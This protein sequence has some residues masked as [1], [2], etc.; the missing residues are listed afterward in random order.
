MNGIKEPVNTLIRYN[1]LVILIFFISG[2][3]GLIYETLWIKML[4]LILGNSIYAI[5]LVVATY[6]AGLGIGGLLAGRYIEKRRDQLR[7]YAILEFAIGIYAMASPFIIEFLKIAYSLA[8]EQLASSILL[9]NGYRLLLAFLVLL[10]P[11][12]IMGATLPV[13]SKYLVRR[14]S[15]LGA[16]IGRLY[17]FNTLGAMLGTV[18]AGFFLVQ[19]FGVLL[20]IYLTAALNIAVG[21]AA[22]LLQKTS[23]IAQ[24]N[25]I[26]EDYNSKAK[27]P[28]RK[29]PKSILQLI[30]FTF[31]ITGFT[32]I[33]YEVIWTRALAFFVGHTTYAFTT[34]LATFLMGLGLGSV[35]ISRFS[36]R[37]K[38]PI[39]VLG[40]IEIAIGLSGI[41]GLPLIDKA[42]YLLENMTG[43]R[44]WGTP[45]WIK[46]INTSAVMLLPA[47]LMGIAFPLASRIFINIKSVGRELGKVYFIN[48]TGGI[49][50][51]FAAVFILIPYMG[52]QISTISIAVINILLGILLLFNSPEKFKFGKR[53]MAIAALGLFI[54]MSFVFYSS[55]V[56]S[57]T[58]RVDWGK[59]IYYR[60]GLN[61][62]I[63]I[64]ERSDG[65]RDLF[66][67]GE[68]N[69]STSPSGKLV[70]MLLAQLPILLH[71]NPD[72]ILVVGLGSGM[73]SG[74]ALRFDGCRVTCAEIS[75]DIIDAARRFSEWNKPL[76]ESKN[77][78]FIVDDGRITLLT[79]PRKYDIII[80]GIIHPKYNPGN[81]SL[82]SSDYY[83]LCKSRLDD[84]G[85]MCQWLPLNAL[86]E[87][88][89][90][91]II[92][93][94]MS[95][96]RHTSLWFEELYGGPGNYNAILIGTNSV[97]QYNYGEIKKAAFGSIP[98]FLS[99]EDYDIPDTE[100][101]L[102]RFIAVDEDLSKYAGSQPLI[103]DNNPR[104]EFGTVEVKDF[105]K[106]LGDLGHVKKNI[107]P[108]LADLPD[109]NFEREQIQLRLEKLN[110][111][112]KACIIGDAYRRDGKF[113]EFIRQYRIATL[114]APQNRTLRDKLGK[115]FAGGFPDSPV[116]EILE[117]QALL[118]QKKGQIDASIELAT[119]A[120]ALSPEKKA[121]KLELGQMFQ[122]AKR[123]DEAI[124]F[125]NE[126]LEHEPDFLEI[127]N[128]LGI[129]YMQKN[130]FADAEREFEIITRQNA[131]FLPMLVNKALLY[132]KTDR[133]EMAIT[134]LKRAEQLAPGDQKIKAL[135]TDLQ[136]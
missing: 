2:A 42:F 119:I 85:I 46:F 121:I 15:E 92:G 123:F 120:M 106:I 30:L 135:V 103:T 107:W 94:F 41:L 56:F 19:F 67:D 20:S 55:G 36:D 52:I 83:K 43:R 117:A 45:I 38:S 54:I 133:R 65:S 113:L 71:K 129:V 29:Y 11:T 77:V 99:Y 31:A 14:N 86:R 24:S 126:I 97:Q 8:G 89:F 66:I 69:A 79:D 37:I 50:G 73:T 64:L 1:P 44:V 22:L 10:P 90:K 111:L 104:L 25:H 18:A 16:G 35:I 118:L 72:D 51:S 75:S 109:S 105:S 130:L 127:R 5:S 116:D 40:L 4:S 62:T 33:A 26:Q 125:Y 53:L 122:S 17:G 49:M 112:S 23:S 47:V 101:L 57:A 91:M 131:E 21:I 98:S 3:C 88:E 100:H 48:T 27:E 70:H 84:N 28:P 39:A 96:F 68:L 34:I 134:I 95:V 115:L 102:D 74:A 9:L 108:Y 61:N 7:I 82:Y 136:K 59:S 6:M 81:A 12:I 63:E 128:N 13:L 58:K 124:E 114:I 80:T 87:S 93:T 60:E 78:N 132:A 110:E 76:F 32:S